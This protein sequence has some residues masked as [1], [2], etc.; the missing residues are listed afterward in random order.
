MDSFGQSG[1]KD[2]EYNEKYLLNKWTI[3][4]EFQQLI[5]IP[6]VGIFTYG[7]IYV[8]NLHIL[9]KIINIMHYFYR[10]RVWIM[11]IK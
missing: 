2:V 9:C 4:I 1:A 3:L 10:E 5:C 11:C 6:T 7:F 8:L